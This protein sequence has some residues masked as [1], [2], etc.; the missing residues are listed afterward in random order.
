MDPLLG[1]GFEGAQ[2]V[3]SQGLCLTRGVDT[4][5]SL[6]DEPVEQFIIYVDECVDYGLDILDGDNI[7]AVKRQ[8]WIIEDTQFTDV[9]VIIRATCEDMAIKRLIN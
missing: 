7:D 4:I 5:P 2:L 8:T 6:E 9:Q 3:D 1:L